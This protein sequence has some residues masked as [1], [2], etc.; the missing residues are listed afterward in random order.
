[1]KI[2]LVIRNHR[3]HGARFRALDGDRRGGNPGAR[4]ISDAS[5]NR[6]AYLGKQ[7][8]TQGQRGQQELSGAERETSHSDSE[9]YE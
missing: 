8:A 6:G 4:G 9:A 5:G 3:P 7:C 1:V 2:T